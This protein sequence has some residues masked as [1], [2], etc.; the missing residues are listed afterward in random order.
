MADPDSIK[1]CECGCGRP[2]PIAT[3]TRARFGHVKGHPMRFVRGHAAVRHGKTKT[4]AWQSWHSMRTRC[5]NPNCDQ[6]PDYGGRG[7]TVCERW[8]TFE[9]F[10]ADMGERPPGTTLDRHPNKDGNYEPGNCRWAV[11]LDQQN[12]RRITATLTHNGRTMSLTNWARE[13][14]VRPHVLRARLKLGWSIDKVLGTPKEERHAFALVTAFD[15]TQSLSA[16]EKETGISRQTIRLRL[17]RGWPAERALTDHV[18]AQAR[19]G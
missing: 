5:F 18:H 9:N 10:L 15:K 12:N 3:S 19:S 4:P 7:I 16:W 11:P 6:W 14:R 1:L 2:A 13:L 8:H 17:E